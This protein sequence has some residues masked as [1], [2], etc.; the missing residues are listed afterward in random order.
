MADIKTL[1]KD[2]RKLI[3]DGNF[4]EAQECCKN[5]LRA[6]KQNY[7]G[8]V[9]F[10]K[11]LQD[12]DQAPLA[13]Q[14]A[15]TSKRD[16]PLA[17][18][19]LA[20]VYERKSD[21]VSKQ[22]LFSIYDEM[23]YLQM[24]EEKTEE[25]ITKMGQLGV[26]LKSNQAIKFLAGYI[27][28]GQ[29]EKLKN[30][31]ETQVLELLKVDTPCNQEDL[32]RI[33]DIL[34]KLYANEPSDSLE[35]LQCKVVLQKSDINS[36][37]QDLLKFDFFPKKAMLKEFVCQ[38][39]CTKY[40]E[41]MTFN[42]LD[43]EKWEMITKGIETSKH[44]SLLNSMISYNKGS[45]LEA[46]KLCVPL[47]NYNEADETEATFI[48]KC[49]MM[50]KKWPIMQK[51]A[52]NFIT[53]AKEEK[54][55]LQL[56]IFL[57]YSLAKQQKWN[58]AIANAKLIPLDALGTE[59]Q[60][61]LAECYI[62]I[63][64]TADHIMEN[65]KATEYHK[66]L[67]AL[68][69][70]KKDKY[71]E[72]VSLL[73]QP[74]DNAL[75]NFYLGKA[76][77]E[78]KEYN[79]C[80]MHLL[81]AAKRNSD[82][83]Y[84]FLYL[85][86]LYCD[87]KNDLSKAKKCY[88]KAYSLNNTDVDIVKRLSEIYIKLQQPELNFELLTTFVKNVT[89]VEP[90]I[91][92]R[93]GLQNLNKRDWES[94]IVN[95]RNVIKDNKN[96]AVA[97]ECL[98]DSYYSRGSYTSALRAYNKVMSLDPSKATYCLT[99]IGY[100]H[101]LLTNYQE[102]I[103]TFENV[104][105]MSPPSHLALKGIAETWIRVAKKKL[106]AK[107]FGSARSCAQYAVTYIIE[108]I[109]KQN[110]F[111]C[112]WKLL[113]DTLVFITKLPDQY[114]HVLIPHLS[115]DS[116]SEPVRKS[117]CEIILQAI[118]CYSY[119]AKQKQL[120]ASYELAYTY[121]LYYEET[122]EVI[123]G[124]IAFNLASICVKEKPNS[125]RNCNLL[126]KI[127]LVLNKYEQAQHCFIK[128]LMAT[129]KLSAA[130]IWC[131]LGSLYIKLKLYKLANYCFWRGQSTLPSYPQS[132]IGQ[133]II[134]EV[135]RE[136]EAM[137]LF[138]HA[139]R[140]GYH[141]ESALGY[142]DWVCRTLNKYSHTN[143]LDSKYAIEGLYAIPYAKDLME[144]FSNFEPNNA[145]ANNILG[146]LQ[147]KV[148]L[149]KPAIKSY[150]KAFKYSEDKQKSI[151]LLNI[152]RILLRLE[153]YD[154]AI[155]IF[156]AIP[157]A[158]FNSTVGLALALFKKGLYEESYAAY[159]TALH[160]LCTDEH[161]K[162]ELFVAMAGIIYKFKGHNDAK[163]MLF[164]SIQASQSKPSPYSLLAICSLGITHS[165]QSISKL[166]LSELRKY[167]KETQFIYDIGFLRSYY[168][169]C[170]DDVDQ[171]ISLLSETVLDYPGN[172]LLWFC[173]AQYCL[174]ANNTNAKAASSCARKA[175]CSGYFSNINLVTVYATASIAEY[176]AG[177]AAE[178]LRFAKMGLHLYP[179]QAEI[180]A[181]LLFSLL[182]NNSIDKN[183]LLAAAGHMRRHLS[184]SRPLSRWV[185][186]VEKKLIS[187]SKN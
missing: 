100:I 6:D 165:E 52:T 41:T 118:A 129:K 19:G 175:L 135:I 44:A 155:K 32:L 119:I 97:F 186:L 61:C 14:K 3:D 39:L 76:F 153:K 104:I 187:A 131:N 168:F 182:S 150:E 143:D 27:T 51:L 2:A 174:R 45:Y 130:K 123:N 154:E 148:G 86:Y 115:N 47:I 139:S 93:L 137:D 89:T 12:S 9:L 67:E 35:M 159:D 169:I 16:H 57:F 25:I 37:F 146:V 111:L 110:K 5:I 21:D 136:A 121:F 116:G 158:S 15:I 38:W 79:N 40:V 113:A 54:F 60:A 17:W 82:H 166:A 20:Q 128:A 156:K 73:Q 62:E 85:G 49:T 72:V 134:A 88:E 107:M 112:F 179:D 164:Q 65:L 1:L 120:E 29:N 170:E 114:A 30:I 68:S 11:S 161:E 71:K 167:E 31:A 145:C 94:A 92:F 55:A 144:W 178:A 152:G 81:K 70:L 117:K 160:W 126:G 140:L 147:E 176:L 101:S 172:G 22:K 56:R 8:L 69:Y 149:L 90:W 108:A 10:G 63:D 53:K 58:Q 59:E 91:Y 157:E 141:P 23:L 64:E 180:W 106:E 46:Y 103:T 34:A 102:A 124:Q 105:K 74:S 4:K 185:S 28:K 133:A 80:L 24:E 18:Q 66:Q 48:I 75:Y 127:C 7:F 77:W 43:E 173:L 96:D 162:S 84:T 99:K 132:W 83:A 109:K 95:F 181:A 13:Y 26:R 50:L 177:N 142:A 183:W 122:Q 184:I 87:Q 138:R 36:A 78:L 171:G 163:T 33:L 151:I 42:G 98:A 125:W